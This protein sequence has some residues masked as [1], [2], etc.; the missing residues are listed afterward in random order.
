VTTVKNSSFTLHPCNKSQ[1]T[2]S[3]TLEKPWF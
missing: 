3:Q 2:P 1:T